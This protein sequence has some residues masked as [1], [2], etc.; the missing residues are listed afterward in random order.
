[1]A[2]QGWR[3]SALHRAGGARENGY[4]E[5]FNGSLRDELLDGEIFYSIAEAMVLIGA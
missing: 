4:N 3:E 2:R 1:M 5:S